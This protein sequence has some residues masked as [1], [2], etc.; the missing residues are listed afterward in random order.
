MFTKRECGINNVSIAFIGAKKVNSSTTNPI[1]SNEIRSQGMNEFDL[2][3]DIF[4][5]YIIP[6]TIYLI[7]EYS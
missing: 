5:L 6:K 4:E 2:F 7:I 1:F 3:S